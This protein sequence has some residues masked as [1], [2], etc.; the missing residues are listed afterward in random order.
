MRRRLC[1]RLLARDQAH[2]PDQVCTGRTLIVPDPDGINLAATKAGG[3]RASGAFALQ[4]RPRLA[5]R[6][7]IPGAISDTL[8]PFMV[9]ELVI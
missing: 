3:R 8:T 6:A 4:W 2:I 9:V 1:L 5:D 7:L